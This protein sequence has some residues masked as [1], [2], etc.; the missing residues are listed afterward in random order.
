MTWFWTGCCRDWGTMVIVQSKLPSFPEHWVQAHDLC[1]VPRFS[2]RK[3]VLLCPARCYRGDFGSWAAGSSASV[4]SL[5]IS[6]KGCPLLSAKPEHLG[7]TRVQKY[8]TLVLNQ[9][10]DNRKWL[11]EKM[12]EDDRVHSRWCHV[13]GPAHDVLPNEAGVS[14][15][16][17]HIGSPHSNSVITSSS[18]GSCEGA[19]RHLWT[20]CGDTGVRR[21]IKNDR[22]SGKS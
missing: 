17:S 11:S 2:L 22:T 9:C 7:F 6:E 13:T 18:V 21:D 16:N 5:T 14:S 3:G 1:R 10:T 4:V 12:E 8:S 19:C 15:E 20:E